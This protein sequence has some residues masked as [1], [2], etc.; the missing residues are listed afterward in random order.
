MKDRHYF[1]YSIAFEKDTGRLTIRANTDLSDSR[2]IPI[3][4]FNS[5][6][7]A[8]YFLKFIKENDGLLLSRPD[9]FSDVEV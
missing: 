9:G 1:E 8:E 7:Q 5:Y 4:G 2:F 3:V 6:E